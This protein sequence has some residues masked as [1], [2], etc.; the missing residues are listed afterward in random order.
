MS[1][2]TLKEKVERLIEKAQ[3]GGTDEQYEDIKNYVTNLRFNNPGTNV[4]TIHLDCSKFTSLTSLEGTFNRCFYV[5]EVYLSNTERITTWSGC[6]YST[7]NLWHIYGDLD[8]SSTTNVS[9][10]FQATGLRTISIVPNTVKISIAFN[11]PKLTNGTNGTFNSIQSIF[12]GL[13]TVTTAQTLTLN[14]TLKILQSQVDVANAK[15][16]T[17]AGGTIVS[18]EEYYG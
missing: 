14:A 5:R 3:S 16:W 17:V 9:N 6:F 18:E 10:A 7:N 4:R 2:A 15:G 8:F 11:S 1:L 13:A 12:D